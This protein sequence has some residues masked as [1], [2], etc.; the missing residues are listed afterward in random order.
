[1][2]A[3]KSA[4]IWGKRIALA[5]LVA[6]SLLTITLR[7]T[8][9]QLDK[10]KAPLQEW[11]KKT[12]GSQIHFSSLN[13]RLRFL[14]PSLTLHDLI[15]TLPSGAELLKAKRVEVRF[16]LLESLL[17]LRPTFTN[18]VINGLHLDLTKLPKKD[19]NQPSLSWQQQIDQLLFIELQ[20][21]SLHNSIVVVK[22][23]TGHDATLQVNALDWEY[24]R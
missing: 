2:R 9:P 7:V 19:E 1:M 12:T 3:A 22:D 24:S 11:V 16:D 10:I 8:L 18:F 13:G 4:A 5:L 17:N 6:L 14:L 23:H 20:H 15:L 21:F